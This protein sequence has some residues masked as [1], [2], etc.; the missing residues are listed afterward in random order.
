MRVVCVDNKGGS[1][2]GSF[3]ELVKGK[4]YTVINTH[5]IKGIDYYELLEMGDEFGFYVSMFLP[6]IDDQKDE[7]ELIEERENQLQEL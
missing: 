5:I 1:E 3:P 7:I 2:I 6:I 4:V